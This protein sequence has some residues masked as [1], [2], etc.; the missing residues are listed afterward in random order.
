MTSGRA[1]LQIQILVVEGVEQKAK[2]HLVFGLRSVSDCASEIRIEGIG[3]T[4]NKVSGTV[5]LA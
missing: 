1:D 5:S 4:D 2:H 3:I